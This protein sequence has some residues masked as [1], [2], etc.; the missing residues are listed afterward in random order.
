[1][2]ILFLVYAPNRSVENYI[3]KNRTNFPWIDA[4]LDEILKCEQIIPGLAFPIFDSGYQKY[5]RGRLTIFGLPDKDLFQESKRNR[6]RTKRSKRNDDILTFTAK[7]I[8]DFEPDI[9]QIFGTENI[10]G[11][12]RLKVSIPILIHFQGSVQVVS[13]KW[14]TGITRFDQFRFLS[15]R[16]IIYRKGS[17]YEY[18]RFKERG[19]RE[20][21]VIKSSKYFVGRTNFDRRLINLLSPEA[22]YFH[23][24]EFIRGGFFA[25]K[26]NMQLT[27][28]IS[29]I[30][31]L[32]GVTYK[33]IDL[34]LEA[35]E[36]LTRYTPINV[37]FKICGVR[38][39]EGV[40]SILKRKHYRNASINKV[41]FLGKLDTDELIKELCDSNFFVHPSYME[42]SSNSICEA[43]ALGMP[44]IA[45]N[46]GGT[47]SLIRD[48]IDGILVQE[49]EPFSLTAAIVELIKD[50]NQAK[51]LGENARKRSIDRHNPNILKEKML[52]IYSDILL[53]ELK[54]L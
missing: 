17:F 21:L 53:E 13:I 7:A 23:C 12:I 6:Q 39:T 43:M 24:E 8:D 30:S 19:I 9:I 16:N 26:W 29:C 18:F 54:D 46:V 32:K 31:I 1:M 35:I 36:L 51:I 11:M 40:V 33:G 3:E 50:Y 14:F 2:R 38:E 15:L 52:R 10:F 34:L 27:G 41:L 48:G 45:T 4:M 22:K 37:T 44:V 47:S 5:Q 49:G 42:N 25:S 20:E 28:N